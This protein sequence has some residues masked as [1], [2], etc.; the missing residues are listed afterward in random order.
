MLTW[1]TELPDRRW[2]RD[3]A[4]AVIE[5]NELRA[6]HIEPSRLG[7]VRNTL[8]SPVQDLLDK[9]RQHSRVAVLNVELADL[10]DVTDLLGY[11]L[12][13]AHRVGCRLIVHA[14]R[15][16]DEFDPAAL[17]DERFGYAWTYERT[18]Y[19]I[20]AME[21]LLE[22]P[23]NAGE[24]RPSRVL[25]PEQE[26]AVGAHDGVVQVIAPAGS[27]KTT[28]LI[29]RVRELLRRGNRPERILCLTFNA[30]AR[31]ELQDRLSAAGVDSVEVRTFHSTGLWILRTEG[32]I[33]G[34]PK[35]LSLAQWR[36]LALSARNGTDTGV[37]IE[38]SDARAAVSEFK[39]GRLSTAAEWRRQASPD[40]KS[41]T[42]A[43]LYGL[44]EQQLET[45]RAHDFDDHILLSV[46]ALGSDP[47]LRCRWQDR[48]DHVL[49]D[50]YQDI[51]PA[52]EVLVQALAAPQDSLFVVGDED[53]VLY[54]WRRAS[55]LRIVGLD[56][57]YPGLERVAMV[58]NYRCPP[59]VVERSAQ[60]IAVNRVRFPKTFHSAPGRRR[61]PHAVTH[62]EYG[63]R[64]EAA[65]W[66]ARTLRTKQRGE[67]A[68]LARTVRLLREV[69]VA[70]VA[71]GIRISA[72]PAVFDSRGAAEAVE[73]HL[74][75]AA[76]PAEASPADVLAIL[77]S[78]S[79]GLLPQAEEVLS[80]RLR[81]GHSWSEAAIGLGR[82]GRLESAAE[83]LDASRTISEAGQL[84]RL[85]RA[86]FGLDAHFDE[87]DKTFGGAEQTELEALDDAERQAAGKSVEEYS[88]YL[89][90]TRSA[91]L[92]IR[93][94]D[95]GIQLSTVHGA[96]GREW[97][98]VIVAAFDEDQLPHSKA[99]EV[100][101]EQRASGEGLE[102]ERRVA[103]VAL[104]RAQAHLH[105]LS[106]KNKLSQ[107]AW[108]AGLADEPPS[109]RSVS[110]P[111][112]LLK[113]G[114]VK[115]RKQRRQSRRTSSASDWSSAARGQDPPTSLQIA[116]PPGGEAVTRVG[117][118][119]A[120]R[121]SPDKASGL[122]IASWAIR[123]DLVNEAN[124]AARIT[125][126]DFLL[127]VP[128]IEPEDVDAMLRRVRARPEELVRRL[129][130]VLRTEVADE[131][132]RAVM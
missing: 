87:Y 89:S 123:T 125:L 77:R 60:L 61:S 36:R 122:R 127:N 81:E 51:E 85:L 29:E 106:T 48:F 1:I 65:D 66:T 112:R 19:L 25:D 46:R 90:D 41:Q 42:L 82:D 126:R 50:E 15:R 12:E 26:A 96:K 64:Q 102:A 109:T 27:G 32:L 88:E 6:R 93:D 24:P 5:F 100:S 16:V 79:R 105:V 75:L 40:P 121:A 124:A 35:G 44:Y 52:Q 30:S 113:G 69:A 101:P 38:P 116:R 130:P 120:V 83:V 56:Q 103:Y 33:R 37:W 21:A 2:L 58:T 119:Y 118:G 9:Y 92:A 23:V 68:V 129:S 18:Q 45:D 104:T 67:I 91:L 114:R 128:E 13:P 49:V 98:T 97:P 115:S 86:S 59:E 7:P 11:V 39:L 8:A 95:H 22:G 31:A 47:D 3:Q 70:C 28:V 72:P 54:G 53:Q 34:Q 43:T 17:V 80:Q 74:R 62:D 132:D 73:I 117:A 94:D 76:R 78:P 108:E 14:N 107:F 10:Q 63:T 57:V 4:F 71:Y 99:L 84:L 111:S 110:L 20:Q 131:L 55:A